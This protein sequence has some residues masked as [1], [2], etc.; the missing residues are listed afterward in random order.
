MPSIVKARPS[1]AIS[2]NVA[3]NIVSGNPQCSPSSSG[4]DCQRRLIPSLV[5]PVSGT[6]LDRTSQT[7][8]DREQETDSE[9][10]TEINHFDSL[11]NSLLLIVFNKIGDVKALGRCC[12]ITHRFHGLVPQV[13]NVVNLSTSTSSSS[14]SSLLVGGGRGV[15]GAED[16]NMEA[17]GVTH[18]SP[19]QVLKNFNEIKHL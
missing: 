9:P 6:F 16:D 15:G 10:N 8:K 18:H 2:V 13:D 17:G 12:V 14:S 3:K 5:E 19:T 4:S 7:E 11:P 1:F